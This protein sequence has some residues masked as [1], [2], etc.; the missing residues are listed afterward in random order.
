MPVH[1]FLIQYT[2]GAV[3][4]LALFAAQLRSSIRCSASDRDSRPHGA[5]FKAPRRAGNMSRPPTRDQQYIKS[6]YAQQVID[7]VLQ[8]ENLNL[9]TQP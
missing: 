6:S 1:W 2:C 4:A 9:Y 3:L 5:V 7:F 8:L